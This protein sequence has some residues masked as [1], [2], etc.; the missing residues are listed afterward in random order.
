MSAERGQETEGRQTVRRRLTSG[1]E[2]EHIDLA[3]GGREDESHLLGHRVRM[4]RY[5]DSKKSFRNPP[6]TK[7]HGAFLFLFYLKYSGCLP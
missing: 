5:R 3:A 7:P 2:Q 4:R 1:E 6:L